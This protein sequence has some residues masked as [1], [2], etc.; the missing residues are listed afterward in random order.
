MRKGFCFKLHRDINITAFKPL[1]L[2][3]LKVFS[4]F[5]WDIIVTP[6]ELMYLGKAHLMHLC[7]FGTVF[8]LLLNK[9]SNFAQKYQ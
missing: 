9:G 4:L 6:W 1:I 3:R 2:L 7:F 5:P 8:A